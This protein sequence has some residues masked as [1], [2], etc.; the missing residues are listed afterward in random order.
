MN[1]D[2]TNIWKGEFVPTGISNRVLQCDKNIQEREGYAADLDIDN[3][4]KDLHHIVHNEEISDSGL[5]SGC[6]YIDANDT[7]EH[8]TIKL[9]STIIN[10]KNK[11]NKDYADSPILIY[12]N[13]RC[14]ILLNN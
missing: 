8:P 13:S 4:K 9:V 1:F 5:L 14:I 3:F 12:K 6:F 2:F 7:W 11:S 10:Y